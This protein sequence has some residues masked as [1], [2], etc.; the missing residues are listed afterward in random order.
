MLATYDLEK[1]PTTFDFVTW[2]SIAMG[3]GAT[4]VSFI[5][6]DKIQVKKYPKDVAE[7]R[8]KDILLPVCEIAGVPVVEGIGKSFPYFWSDCP[9]KPWKFKYQKKYDHRTV[10]IRDSF[11]N[12]HRNSNREAWECFAK[13][14][15]AVVIDDCDLKPIPLKERW[16]LYQCRMN[17]FVDNG[18]ANLCYF[19]DAP[20]ISMKFQ[21]TPHLEKIGFPKGAQ[22]PWAN[23]NQKLVWEDDTYENLTNLFGSLG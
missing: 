7:K 15:G 5:N 10:T 12:P 11:R 8:F 6:R 20:Y 16:D 9:R 21:P 22:I 19:S 23:K 1:Q 3:N 18:P 4:E 2:L 13:D 14:I 17:L